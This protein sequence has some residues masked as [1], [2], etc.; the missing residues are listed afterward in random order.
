MTSVLESAGQGSN[1]S[2]PALATVSPSTSL[3]TKPAEPCWPQLLPEP[4]CAEAAVCA[5]QHGAIPPG[6]PSQN[7][8]EASRHRPKAPHPIPPVE[9]GKKLTQHVPGPL[10]ANQSP[11][12]LPVPLERHLAGRGQL[13]NPIIP[14]FPRLFILSLRICDWQS[15]LQEFFSGLRPWGR[16]VAPCPMVLSGHEWR[17]SQALGHGAHGHQ[18][19]CRGLRH[20]DALCGG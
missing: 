20:W 5:Q 9:T 16:L 17:A 14:D 3:G 7:H 18:C 10:P 12:A 8:A 6:T 13:L 11:S 15:Q 4:P 1:L 2:C 19:S